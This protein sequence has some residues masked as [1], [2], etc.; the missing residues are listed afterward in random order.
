MEK[1]KAHYDLADIKAIVARYGVAVFT[2]TAR[3]GFMSM[4]LSA[5]EALAV[6]ASLSGAM[7][8]KSMT[9]HADHRVWQ[10]VYHP[11]KLS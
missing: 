2:A 8:F 6:V 9:A 10:D 5:T 7:L 1:R 3:S 11:R 4:G